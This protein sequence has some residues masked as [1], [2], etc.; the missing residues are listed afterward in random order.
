MGAHLP[1][2]FVIH[3]IVSASE[4]LNFLDDPLER[5]PNVVWNPTILG[6]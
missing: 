2:P 3:Q 5:L 1:E 4:V 6:K